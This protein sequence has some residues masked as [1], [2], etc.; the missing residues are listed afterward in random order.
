[1]F[2]N[3]RAPASAPADNMPRL[4]ASEAQAL[5]RASFAQY[6]LK[7]LDMVRASLAETDDLFEN[8]SHIPNGDVEIFRTKRG[9]WLEQ[10]AAGHGP[11]P[12]LVRLKLRDN[13]Q[14]IDR[15]ATQA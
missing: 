4:P 14:E 10:L 6:R 1:M 5:L 13:R 7:L 9:A 2:T 15:L 3:A 11:R 12:H 8:N